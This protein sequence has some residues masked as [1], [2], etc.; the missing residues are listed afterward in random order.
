MVRLEN[1]RASQATRLERF[2]EEKRQW[3]QRYPGKPYQDTDGTRFAE[4]LS[5]GSVTVVKSSYFGK[6]LA[7]NVPFQDRA[8]IA[9]EWF[10]PAEEV[11]PLW[12]THGARFLVVVSYSWL[13]QKHPDPDMFHLQRLTRALKELQAC[14]NHEYLRSKL[15]LGELD[16]LGV[17]IDYCS[18]H[19]QHGGVDTRSQ[20]Q[21]SQFND[22]LSEIGTPFAHQDVTAIKLVAVPKDV[23]R[24]YDDR[25]W[26]LFETVLID[27]KNPSPKIMYCG[28][29][30]GESN[31]LTI[32]D[33]LDPERE[34][35]TGFDFV[36]KFTKAR[37]RPPRTPQQFEN[38]MDL[39]WLRAIEKSVALFI[40]MKDQSVLLETY[41]KAFKE[42][43]RTEKFDFKAMNW[44]DEG[45]ATF[46]EVLVHCKALKGL[47]LESN[48]ISDIGAEKLA[49]TL[50]NTTK[51]TD[52]NLSANKIGHIGA[53]NLAAT[54]P[55]MTKLAMLTLSWNQIGNK[56]AEILARSLHS[57]KSLNTLFLS[58]NNIGDLGASSIA[59]ELPALTNLNELG[60]GKNKIGDDGAQKVAEA[61]PKMIN[62]ATLWIGYNNITNIGWEK[63]K[64]KRLP[65]LTELNL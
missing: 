55:T 45:I 20:E 60:L 64:E 31:V 13:T 24:N 40:N 56:G 7:E 48:A 61:L 42:L 32:G 36:C 2:A 34:K 46:T 23:M 33:D 28:A 63:L 21:V 12:N 62:L 5:Q 59:S 39:R 16:E 17:I 41:T 35:K 3:T 9:D 6:C 37:F 27:G 53:E 8:N 4:L 50:L 29:S 47:N 30:L 54:L 44:G 38:E 43:T 10:I 1:E 11:M 25:G 15:G 49:T 22:A 51:L 18:L 26:T 19:Q 52:L 57:M 58:S 14:H 65:S